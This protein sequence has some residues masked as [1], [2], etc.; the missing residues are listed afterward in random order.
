MAKLPIPM[1]GVFIQGTLTCA[2]DGT[3]LES[4]ALDPAVAA[5]VVTFADEQRR[6]LVAFC[7]SRVLCAA[8][9]EDTD[10][11][12]D[13]GEPAPEAVGSLLEGCVGA[14][15]PVN[16]LLLFAP[17]EDMPALRLEAKGL[18]EGV[19]AITTAIPGMLEFLPP[20]VCKGAAVSRLLQRLGVDPANVMSLGD[21]E[22]DVEM[23]RLAGL[24]VAMAGSARAVVEAA[25][26]NVGLSNDEHGVADAIERYVL[27]SRGLGPAG[28][29]TMPVRD[30]HVDDREGVDTEE[31]AHT[32]RE[33]KESETE[34]G[35]EAGKEGGKGRVEAVATAARGNAK[36]AE[37]AEVVAAGDHRAA[38]IK[39]AMDKAKRMN[40]ELLESS[41]KLL[42]SSKMATRRLAELQGSLDET[43]EALRAEEVADAEA[44]LAARK[45]TKATTGVWAWGDAAVGAT[46]WED[47]AARQQTEEVASAAAAATEKAAAA[48]AT[49]EAAATADAQQQQRRHGRHLNP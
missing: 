20:G 13:Y 8:R 43:E 46:S 48:A 29:T 41:K 10:R 9:D 12:L 19:C 21:G 49:A 25:G 23:L 3:V 28:A 45:T 27:A 37:E 36:E 39:A 38:E 2:A 26:G 16:K 44:D 18:F 40:A 24:G 22:N 7:G 17:V 47:I 31:N 30:Q 11:I 35:E 42:E 34:E 1:P 4:I 33:Q 14:G 5:S 32:I 15:I 6:T